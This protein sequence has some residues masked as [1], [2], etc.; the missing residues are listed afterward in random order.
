VVVA[1][2]F[3]L[4]VRDRPELHPACNQREVALIEGGQLPGS[5]KIQP[6]GGGL[7][8]VFLLRSRSLLLSSISQ[9]ATNLGWVFLITWLPRYLA[10]VHRVPVQERG[11]M[12]SLPLLLGMA[13]MLA[14]GWL[15]D[16][17]TRE[18]GLRWGRALPM[19]LTRFAGAAAFAAC[20]L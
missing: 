11:W 15:T 4:G 5:G 19:G 1:L 7:P 17:L 18:V 20:L 12:A 6:V 13:G 2:V 3:W 9:F 14:G 16:R 10:E 8:L